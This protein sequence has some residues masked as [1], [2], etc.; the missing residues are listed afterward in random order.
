MNTYPINAAPID[1]NATLY[2]AGGGLLALI[3]A[4]AGLLGTLGRGNARIILAGS[5]QTLSALAGYGAGQITLDGQGSAIAGMAAYG[6]ARIMI[7][8]EYGLPEVQSIPDDYS[9]APNNRSMHIVNDPRRIG[10]P[11]SE[12]IIIESDDRT[13]TIA[14]EARTA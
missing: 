4:G 8:A 1:G 3:G 7:A 6:S 12:A 9:P 11:G 5:G 14:F 10:I 2:G 13:D